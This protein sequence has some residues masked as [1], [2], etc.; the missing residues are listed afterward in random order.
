M[1]T[2]LSF[3][4]VS[5]DTVKN[6]DC[7]V[8]WVEQDWTEWSSCKNGLKKK[9]KSESLEIRIEQSGSGK[10][11]PNGIG[12]S[13]SF[14][15]KYRDDE[16]GCDSELV[17]WE[18]G[19]IKCKSESVST[20]HGVI[21]KVLDNNYAK[22]YGTGSITAICKDTKW[23]YTLPI[24]VKSEDCSGNWVTIKGCSDDGKKL[25]KFITSKT[26]KNLGKS[27]QEVYNANDGDIRKSKEL[28]AQ[29]KAQQI[30]WTG[31]KTKC[32]SK[33]KVSILEGQ[34][35][36]LNDLATTNDLQYGKFEGKCIGGEVIN[37]NSSCQEVVNCSGEWKSLNSCSLSG[38]KEEEF[39]VTKKAK[40]GGQ[41]CANAHK[42][43]R[44][45]NKSCDYCPAVVHTWDIGNCVVDMPKIKN[46]SFT[47]VIKSKRNKG[48]TIGSCKD[49]KWEF[50]DSRCV[51][52]CAKEELTW[53]AS[54]VSCSKKVKKSTDGRII[55]LIDSSY[56]KKGGGIGRAVASCE[57]GK[58][59]VSSGN[60]SEM[61]DCV[62]H[63]E[64]TKKCDDNNKRIEKYII[65]IP[66]SN[67]G[68]NCKFN[69]DSM[70]SSKSNC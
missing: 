29:C 13:T 57:N 33:M 9:T 21:S 10:K 63:W 61:R 2:L 48:K 67:D 49:G 65:T 8:S 54:G 22:E 28:C 38:L 17:E 1:F 45:T 47:E 15:I 43:K 34:T 14:D 41:S 40:N 26:A 24:C 5:A 60:C 52:D 31:N 69:E 68:E 20:E 27:C 12:S 62:G 59:Y 42:K 32:Q 25:E 64:K 56:P 46:N 51:M 3:G 44:N 55:N 4:N 58:W 35:V 7:E 6:I 50:E 18:D 53:K 11:C 39:I 23:K 66:P 36:T 16:C 37:T 19:G 70:R 30:K